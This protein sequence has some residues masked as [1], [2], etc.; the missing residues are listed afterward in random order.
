MD[1]IDAALIRSAGAGAV[2]AGGFLGLPY[3]GEMR[4][5]LRAVLGG[6]GAVGEVERELTLCH[7][8]AV[9]RLLAEAGLA[10]AAV[11]VIGFHGHTILHRPQERRTWQIG[12]GALLADRKSTRLNSSH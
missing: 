8:E 11:R 2:T 9:R 6:K 7:A 10:P 12:D 3:D 5:R 4:R 1:G